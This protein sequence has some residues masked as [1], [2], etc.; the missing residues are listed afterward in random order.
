[1]RSTDYRPVGPDAQELKLVGS[2]LSRPPHKND[3]EIHPIFSKNK[4]ESK[5]R[6]TGSQLRFCTLYEG[7]GQI[8]G[9]KIPL[10][11]FRRKISRK[12]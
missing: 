4:V 11:S 9:M 2:F 7:S 3:I 10:Y 6:E 8:L 12:I 5:N 1:M